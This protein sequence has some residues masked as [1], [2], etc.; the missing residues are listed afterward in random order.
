MPT[1]ALRRCA[2]PGCTSRQDA[3][4]CSLHV[5]LRQRAVDLARGSRQSRGYDADW[6]R[7]RL[8]VLERDGHRCQIGGPRCTRVATTVDHMVP[9]AQ[10]GAR[11]D[12]ANLRPACGSCNSRLG[13]AVR[14]DRGEGGQ[15]AGVFEPQDRMAGGVVSR[16]GFPKVGF[17][18]RP[19][20][21]G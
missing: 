10:G 5:R 14:R 4:R 17:R 19:S 6:E 8:A 18:E 16:P 2:E 3:T 15:I 13:G 20:D 1:A 11:L 21:G 12:P 9:L 7:V